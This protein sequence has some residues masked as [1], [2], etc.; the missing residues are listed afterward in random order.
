MRG[1]SDALGFVASVLA[2]VVPARVAMIGPLQM[3]HEFVP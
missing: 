3:G 1:R 2:L